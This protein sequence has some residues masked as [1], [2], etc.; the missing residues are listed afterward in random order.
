MDKIFTAEE[1]SRRRKLQ[2]AFGGLGILIVAFGVIQH[3]VVDSQSSLPWP[4]SLESISNGAGY[5]VKNISEYDS[6]PNPNFLVIVPPSEIT[7]DC[8]SGVQACQFYQYVSRFKCKSVKI[9][10][11]FT[12]S[13]SGVSES[14]EYVDT[15]GT[16]GLQRGPDKSYADD[17]SKIIEVDAKK[18]AYDGTAV[19]SISCVN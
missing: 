19:N 11:N 12:N 5:I 9:R 16:D 18:S 1:V 8:S 17:A 10:V 3:L 4:P 14:V 7:G 13:K 15:D 6:S 2:A